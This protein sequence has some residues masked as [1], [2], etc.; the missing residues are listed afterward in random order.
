MGTSLKLKAKCVR[1]PGWLLVVGGVLYLVVGAA[2]RGPVETAVVVGGMTALS[3]FGVLFGSR[4][5]AMLGL[6][7]AA[8]HLFEAVVGLSLVAIGAHSDV[9]WALGE[10]PLTITLGL[11]L[12]LIWAYGSGWALL[13]AL[14]WGVSLRS[15]VLVLPLATGVSALF[16]GNWLAGS[17]V[18][19]AFGAL[20]MWSLWRDRKYFKSLAAKQAAEEAH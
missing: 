12:L 1:L 4:A 15:L 5:A 13:A 11:C 20:L 14:E 2:R 17:L 3:G 19:A 9:R 6:G 16:L 10:A 7:L 8:R 18:T